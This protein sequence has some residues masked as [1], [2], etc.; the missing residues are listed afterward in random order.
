MFEAGVMLGF[1]RL[2]GQADWTVPAEALRKLWFSP[3]RLR[4]RLMRG[5]VRQETRRR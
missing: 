2:A 5:C 4:V 1:Y 3:S